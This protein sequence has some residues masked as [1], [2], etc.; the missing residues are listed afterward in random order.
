VTELLGTLGKQH[1][2]QGES[3]IVFDYPNRLAT[4]IEIRIDNSI[5]GLLHNDYDYTPSNRS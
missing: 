5:N 1:R 4:A 2:I 3:A